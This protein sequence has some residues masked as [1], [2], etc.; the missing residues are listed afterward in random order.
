MTSK[1]AVPRE[2][3]KE[4]E[5]HSRQHQGAERECFRGYRRFAYLSFT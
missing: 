4:V 2:V 1:A 5:R 3:E